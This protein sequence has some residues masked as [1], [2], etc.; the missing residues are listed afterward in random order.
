MWFISNLTRSSW[1]SSLTTF[2]SFHAHYPKPDKDYKVYS[3][4]LS[5][6]SV[7]AREDEMV[8]WLLS[9]S[10]MFPTMSQVKLLSSCT[11]MA[12]SHR[13]RLYMFPLK[14]CSP[15]HKHECK[16]FKVNIMFALQ[17]FTFLNDQPRCFFYTKNCRNT[18]ESL[19]NEKENIPLQWTRYVFTQ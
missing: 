7:W 4:Q 13:R 10:M 12:W 15:K 17:L 6:L 9:Q 16:E 19:Q 5:V 8:H 14:L 18:S 11:V 3:L 1:H 2:Q